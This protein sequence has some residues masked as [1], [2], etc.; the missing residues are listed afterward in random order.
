MA[1]T[2]SSIANVGRTAGINDWK[3]PSFPDSTAAR[4]DA[5]SL[6]LAPYHHQDPALSPGCRKRLF[7][8]CLS[9]FSRL[10]ICKD[11]HGFLNK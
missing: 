7:K 11:E 5:C 6:Y 3:G 4:S 8:K 9:P 1:W 2:V 10:C